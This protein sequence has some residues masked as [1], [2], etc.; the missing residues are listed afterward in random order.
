VEKNSIYVGMAKKIKDYS[1]YGEIDAD[2]YKLLV[3][4]RGEKNEK[5]ELKKYFRLNSPKK[6][7]ERKG[8]KVSFTKGG[9]L[10]YRGK[11]INDL[12]KRMV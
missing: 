9:A 4:K 5:G 12:I 7:F 3:E 2:T 1:T 8:I 6:G 11:K 10:G